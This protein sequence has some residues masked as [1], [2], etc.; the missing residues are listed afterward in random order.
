VTRQLISIAIFLFF[1]GI[2]RAQ[3]VPG[4]AHFSATP[5]FSG[6]TGGAAVFSV[7]GSRGSPDGTQNPV[8]IAQKWANGTQA[9]GV[10]PTAE[11]E[12]WK[13]SNGSNTRATAFHA[14]AVDTA[15]WSGSGSNSFIEAIRGDC[16]LLATALLGS[17]YGGVFSALDSGAAGTHAILSGV[18]ADLQNRW[19]DAT[20]ANYTGGT[21]MANFIATSDG[22]HLVHAAF[23]VNPNTASAA[24]FLWGLH[25]PSGAVNTV[26]A[27]TPAITE[28]AVRLDAAIPWSLDASRCGAGKCEVA[29][30]N[31]SALWLQDTGSAGR[32]SLVLANDNLL[33]LGL[34]SAI[35]AIVLGSASVTTFSAG[36]FALGG[37]GGPQLI[38]GTGAPSATK[39]KGTIFIRT[40]GGVGS[41]IYVSQ[42]GGTWNAV[43]GV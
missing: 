9:S 37:M 11:V 31:N 5:D 6:G 32:N 7:L 1:G 39:P 34:D 15:G 8:W 4:S 12:I 25:V 22:T 21:L 30:P 2:A 10:N 17:C 29:L 42:G 26:S 27:N 24:R 3:L 18:E 20:D 16:R 28:A 23:E 38:A 35:A 14:N 13:S 41:T 33:H 40:D 19:Q 36:P 43:G